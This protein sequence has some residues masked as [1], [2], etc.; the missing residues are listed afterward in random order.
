MQPGSLS[1]KHPTKKTDINTNNDE[2][3]THTRGKRAVNKTIRNFIRGEN[4]KWHGILITSITHLKQL[5]GRERV[6]HILT[7]TRIEKWK[8]AQGVNAANR[9]VKKAT[10]AA[11]GLLREHTSSGTN[12]LPTETVQQRGTSWNNIDTR[13]KSSSKRPTRI[14]TK[15]DAKDAPGKETEKLGNWNRPFSGDQM[16]LA[17]RR[18]DRCLKETAGR[19]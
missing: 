11:P 7:T 5:F 18:R 2:F 13:R 19:A 15:A 9:R 3:R 1:L 8:V 16:V 4:A 17:G 10:L 12:G 6:N 14:C